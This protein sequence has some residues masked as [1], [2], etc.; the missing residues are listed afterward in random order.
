MGDNKTFRD[1]L[2]KHEGFP[3]YPAEVI[4][5]K[6]GVFV[7]MYTTTDFRLTDNGLVMKTNIKKVVRDERSKNNPI[8]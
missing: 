3:V 5:V 2:S 1:A 8:K 4:E 7:E 6:P